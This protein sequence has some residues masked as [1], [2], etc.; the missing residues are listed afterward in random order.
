MADNPLW[1]KPI[2]PLPLGVWAGVAVGGIALGRWWQARGSAPTLGAAPLLSGG[3]PGVAVDG[4]APPAPDAPYDNQAWARRAATALLGEGVDPTLAQRALANFLGGYELTATEDGIVDRAI[5]LIGYPPE[6]VPPASRTPAEPPQAKP[7][8]SAPITPTPQ[9]FQWYYRNQ[10]E[11]VQRYLWSL[12]NPGKAYPGYEP[13]DSAS[14]FHAFYVR[15]SEETQRYLWE[16][17]HPGQ[18]YPGYETA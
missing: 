15:Q 3:T 16:K 9:A 8:H 17:A 10:P 14:Q 2:G 6:A 11:N 7:L 18:P 5:S 4:T 12:G 1:A 13:P